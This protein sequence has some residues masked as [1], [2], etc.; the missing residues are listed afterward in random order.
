[1]QPHRRL[2][3]APRRAV[4]LAATLLTVGTTA[5][6]IALASNS[7]TPA[8]G[9]PIAR[10]L[11]GTVP[12]L[13]SLSQKL[14]L[15]S[16]TQKLKVTL[17]LV[18]PDQAQLNAYVAALYNPRSVDYRRFLTPAQFGTRFGAPAAEVAK[19][20]K[21]LTNLG[22]TVLTPSVNHLD[23]SAVGSAAQLESIFD[24]TLERFHMELTG[25]LKA[26]T[27]EDFFANLSNIRLPAAL[28]GLTTGV[29]GLDNSNEPHP[30]LEYPTAAQAAY[31]R[32]HPQL[33]TP[34]GQDGGATPCVGALAGGGYAASDLA[35]AYDYDGLY[36]KGL[37]GQGMNA[38]LVEFDDFHNSNVNAVESCYGLHIPITRELVDGGTGG[39]PAAGEAEDMLDL[40]TL[41]PLVP[42]L[43]HMYVYEGPATAVNPTAIVDGSSEID[44]YTAFVSQDLAPVLSS[45]W[46]NCEEL[47]GAAY[48][49]LYNTITEEAA[50]QG[51]Q[52]FEGAG[53]SGAVDCRGYPTPTSG[54]ISVMQE[55][56]SPFT[57]GVG[58]TDLSVE[59]TILGLGIHHEDVW[60]DAGAGGGGQSVYAPMPSYQSR[61]LKA[62]GD[63]PP[64][65]IA[66]TLSHPAPCGVTAGYCR[67]IPD[68]SMEADP[69]A[70]GL[71]GQ[72]P[73]PP[74]FLLQGDVG[75]PGV[76]DYCDTSNCSLLS[77]LG[78]PIVPPTVE[79]VGGW[80]PIGGTSAAAPMAAAAAVLWDQQAKAAGLHGGFGFLNPSLYRIASNAAS[81]KADFHNITVNSN[82]AQY[83][84]EDCQAG[85]NPQH[86]YDSARNYSMAAGLGSP[87]VAA[88]GTSL[89]AQA[90]AVDVTPA[91]ASL[92]G[93]AKGASTTAAVAITSGYLGSRF[94]A[95]SSA[96]WL[97]VNRS[98][99]IPGT[100]IWH[101][102]PRQ[103]KAGRYHATIT[104]TNDA[105]DRSHLTISYLVT[106]AAKIAV[107]PGRINFSEYAINSGGQMVAPTCS[108]TV[109]D[110]GLESGGRVGGYSETDPSVSPAS[111]L[112]TVK[113]KNRGPR[114]SILHFELYAINGTGGWLSYNLNGSGPSAFQ[115]GAQAPL[116]PTT[117]TL[118]SGHSEA[119]K[120]ESIA[121][122]NALGGYPAMDQG[123]YYGTVYIRDL[124]NP[125]AEVKLPIT[126]RLGDG[127]GTP[128]IAT[129]TR[130]ISVTEAPGASQTVDLVLSDASHVCG[131]AYSLGSFASWI[132][133]DP[134]LYSGTVPVATATAP[135]TA[136]DTGDG[137][138]FTPLTISAA[139]LAPGTYHSAI[140]INSQTANAN[141]TSVKVTLRVRS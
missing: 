13:V 63:T 76:I 33:G 87:I 135:P 140:T 74:D 27:S 90:T 82:D 24:T 14:G 128:T 61:Y 37:L 29:L 107:S 138:G 20:Q 35:T 28:N 103:L 130:S 117:G 80:F 126:L 83:D 5:G 4:L 75:A 131:Y 85:C 110:D 12:R 127:Q 9:L 49:N 132:E 136:R 111:T 86:L 79:T 2:A 116:V 41:L 44:V 30:M 124:A 95:T 38:A 11:Q 46:G 101:A 104:V 50:A 58:G 115:T 16:A 19:A 31:D 52:I 32:V 106:P 68:I 53:D 89:L 66:G 112:V 88:L 121:N 56:A 123:T 129:D 21:A 141:P 6:S 43:A 34:V 108:G 51:Q 39:P 96:K 17:P 84:F 118:S 48:T 67:M 55:A 91:T 133:V 69:Y 105:G 119:I 71:V 122:G 102:S 8:N 59:S 81:Y 10:V 134:D 22:L 137:N 70:G 3:K 109:W 57:T 78:L 40:A 26:F 1:M 18:L 72:A 114:G 100:L 99:T 98:G 42:K 139:G 25:I 45:S 93:Y 47:D 73:L 64:G 60:N 97:H 120:L 77:E 92:Y 15:L 62:V 54:S 23:V 65:A 94:R 113:V 7:A 125:K 36:K